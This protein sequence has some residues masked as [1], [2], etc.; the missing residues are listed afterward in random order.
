MLKR[1]KK[2]S[3]LV[4]AGPTRAY[5]DRV[6][7]LSNY[8]SGYL[9]FEICRAL[10][11]A[12]VEVTAVVGPCEAPFEKL[13]KTSLVRVETVEEMR[14]AVMGLC[15]KNHPEFAVLSAAVLDFAP[16]KTEK[17]KVSSKSRWHLELIP[18]PKI[19]DEISDKFPEI[20]KVAFKL[21]WEQPLLKELKRF[22]AQNLKSKQA[23]ALCLNYLSQIKRNK[24]SAFLFS[25]EGSFYRAHSKRDIAE[26]ITQY[27]VSNA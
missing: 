20:R 13:R 8:S 3:V 15:K 27:I 22:A 24:H 7:Y 18:T 21:E 9:G 5:L 2:I 16:K 6:R 17:G 14:R 10:E 11:R 26:W 1:S 4:T 25:K 23:D 12:G 19:I